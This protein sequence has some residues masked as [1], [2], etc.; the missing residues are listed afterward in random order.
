MRIFAR[1]LSLGGLL[2]LL[3]GCPG[4]DSEDRR[5]AG[6]GHVGPVSADAFDAAEGRQQGYFCPSEL[7]DCYELFP[8]GEECEAGKLVARFT[9]LPFGGPDICSTAE[10]GAGEPSHCLFYGGSVTSISYCCNGYVANRVN[11]AVDTRLLECCTAAIGSEVVPDELGDDGLYDS[12]FKLPG[13]LQEIEESDIVCAEFFYSEDS[14]SNRHLMEKDGAFIRFSPAHIVQEGGSS[15]LHCD[16]D[17]LGAAV[18]VSRLGVLPD[19]DW[20][21]GE[22]AACYFTQDEASAW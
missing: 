2:V 22:G 19:T 15:R 1:F 10:E 5:A 12:G 18:A 16:P 21:P 20:P 7:A 17:E 3:C 4:L 9:Y 14:P 11:A 6:D 8:E 13:E